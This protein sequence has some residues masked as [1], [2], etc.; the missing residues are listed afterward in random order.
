MTNGEEGQIQNQFIWP[1]QVMV[2]KKPSLHE[3]GFLKCPQIIDCPTD[4]KLN[5]TDLSEYARPVEHRDL[6]Y[7]TFI[8]FNSSDIMWV[9]GQ[10]H[11]ARKFYM[12]FLLACTPTESHIKSHQ[13]SR[14]TVKITNRSVL[15]KCVSDYTWYLWLM[16]FHHS[17]DRLI[18][19]E[20][21]T[22]FFPR[23]LCLSSVPAGP[24]GV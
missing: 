2:V 1:G 18:S 14:W 8:L 19:S 23:P 20:R 6:T 7:C 15:E 11:T 9:S 21:E 4:Y 10:S 17:F 16:H 22:F 3:E 12:K 13:Q 24:R 5:D